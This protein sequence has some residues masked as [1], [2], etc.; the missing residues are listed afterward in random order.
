MTTRVKR[1]QNL[2]NMAKAV[3]WTVNQ[4]S[5]YAKI[6]VPGRNLPVSI[7]GTPGTDRSVQN[8]EML[9][10][11][12]GLNDAYEQMQSK[13]EAERRDKVAEVRRRANATLKAAEQRIKD[14]QPS[15]VATLMVAGKA[16]GMRIGFEEITPEIALDLITKSRA[17]ENFRQRRVSQTQVN[18]YSLLMKHD[19]WEQYMPDGIVG[20]DTEGI[21]VN[22][23]HRMLAVIASGKTIGFVVARDVPRSMFPFFDRAKTRTAADVYEIDGLPSSPDIQ[24]AVKLAMRYEQMFRGVLDP[25][26]WGTWSGI[27]D[28]NDDALNFYRRNKDLAES[29]QIGRSLYY[30]ARMVPAAAGVFH[31]Y[32]DKAWPDRGKD[33]DGFDPLDGFVHLVRTG[34][35]MRN[36]APAFVL[37]DWSKDVFNLKEKV[38][39]KR[40][41]QLFLAYRHWRMHMEGK[42]VPG[43]RVQYQRTWAMPL[44]YHPDGDKAAL[45][46]L[47]K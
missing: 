16:H 8:L 1:V 13:L 44:P 36:V 39:Q 7:P 24:S 33:K 38:P 37:R 17:A 15:T 29:V 6:Y 41:V 22:G 5:H 34:E 10:A 27:K 47:I 46:N 2:I 18:D 42:T 40:E 31:Y 25:S 14:T 30:G 23:Q 4:G 35:N 26:T 32:A 28:T 9:L 21:L 12:L 43:G 11:R 19:Q 20:I 3:D 45:E